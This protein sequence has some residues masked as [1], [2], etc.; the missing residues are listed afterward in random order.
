MTILRIEKNEDYTI[1]PNHVLNDTRL[2]LEARGLL[3]YLLSKPNHW[4]VNSRALVHISPAG[5]DK[6]QRILRELER[7]GYLERRRV[8][9]EGGKFVWESVIREMPL[10]DK[11]ITSS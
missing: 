10:Q 11:D 8:R 4:R 6:I 9:G 7:Y 1:L 5:R 2:S 3:A